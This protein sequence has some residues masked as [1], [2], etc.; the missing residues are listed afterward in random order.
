MNSPLY[1]PD[2]GG[3]RKAIGYAPSNQTSVDH[4]YTPTC[5]RKEGDQTNAA[6]WYDQANKPVCK[7]SLDAEWLSIANDLLQR[8]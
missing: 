5:H 4:G 8:G 6:Y 3:A 1:S 2:C 7:E